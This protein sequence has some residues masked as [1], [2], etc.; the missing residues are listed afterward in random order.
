MKLVL[1]ISV[2]SKVQVLD[3]SYLVIYS[4]FSTENQSMVVCKAAIM[5]PSCRNCFESSHLT[6]G[7]LERSQLAPSSLRCRI[8]FGTRGSAHRKARVSRKDA[9]NHVETSQVTTLVSQK[10]AAYESLNK[11]LARSQTPTVLYHAS[12]QRQVS[13]MKIWW[14]SVLNCRSASLHSE[15]F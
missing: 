15:Y 13:P 5:L 8:G 4:P 2:K 3:N 6:Y 7:I 1:I 14:L 12:S 10:A 11:K 9:E